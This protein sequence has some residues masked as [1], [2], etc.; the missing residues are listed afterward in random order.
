MLAHLL[1]FP[2]RAVSAQEEKMESLT[3]KVLLYQKTREGLHDIVS[4][5]APRV[6]QFP[7]RK[8]GW[9]EDACGEFFVFVHPRLIRLLDRFSDQGKPFESYLSAVLNWQLRN[10]AR[11]RKR[12]ERS[13]NVS[14][15][16][17][18]EDPEAQ[19]TRERLVSEPTAEIVRVPGDFAALI[20][21]NADRRNFLFL[22]LKCARTIGPENAPALAAATGIDESRILSLSASLREMRAPREL[23]LEVFRARRNRAFAQSRLLETELQA[24]VEAERAAVLRASLVKARRRMRAAMHRMARVKLAPTNREIARAVGVPKGTVDSGLYWLKRKLASVYDPDIPRQ[25]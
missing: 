3:E 10:F 12:G 25:A 6:Y 13:W 2:P 19:E 4:A 9:D 22:A 15:R 21:S 18:A 1:L 5:L 20:R 7:R 16:L 14:L 23:R 17:D 24:E 11:D 8:M